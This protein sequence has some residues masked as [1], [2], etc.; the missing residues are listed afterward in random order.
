[1]EDKLVSVI[2]P[3]YN[4]AEMLREAIES[5]LCQTYE[6]FELLI[7]D[8]CSP[9]HTPDVVASFNDPRI[10]YLR[11]QCNIGSSANWTYGVRLAKGMY[12]SVL[13]DDDKFKPEFINRRIRAFS[14][15]D[16]IAAAFSAYDFC[17]AD[18]R[19]YGS[20]KSLASQETIVEGSNL[21]KCAVQ[22]GGWSLIATMYRAEIVK[23]I[24]DHITLAG[25]AGDTA[26]NIH[27]ALI[28]DTCAVWLTE[29]DV[30]YRRHAGQDCISTEQVV[31]DCI[32]A[33]KEPVESGEALE[34][35]AILNNGVVWANNLLGRS[36]WD[37]G[38]VS[39]ARRYFIRELL[40]DPFRLRTWFRLIRSY[41]I[42][43]KII[44]P[45]K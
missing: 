41:V 40:A 13:A 25:K 15:A 16:N 44:S 4:R 19:I 29:R 3:T 20:S 43:P 10:K 28:P 5:V 14:K 35:K 42:R 30:I 7:L 32:R 6:N 8:N 22:G 1:M 31:I 38:K 9:D 24:W 34:Y 21:V 26:L 18:G 17:D 37:L 27:I 11:H 36:A 2:I 45:Y 23:N 33:H 39:M 12:L